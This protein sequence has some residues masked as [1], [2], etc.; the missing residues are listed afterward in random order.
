MKA[1]SLHPIYADM[2]AA[3]EKIEEYRT[4]QTP[5]RGDLLIC[6][7]SYNDGKEFVRS[8]AICIAELYDIKPPR[9]GREFSWLLRNVRLIEPFPIKGKLH[10][11]DVDDELIKP[12][13][14][15]YDELVD[16]WRGLGL[17]N[18]D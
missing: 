14:G 11:F 18:D 1:L 9:K 13:H 3:E 5:H 12:F 7:S 2:I 8:H 4:W 6:A 15:S 17:I 10:L 16:H